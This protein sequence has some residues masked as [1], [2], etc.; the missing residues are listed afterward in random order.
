MP[1]W[2]GGSSGRSLISD[3]LGYFSFQPV[4]NTVAEQ[5]VLPN[6]YGRLYWCSRN[7][8]A[9]EIAAPEKVPPGAAFSSPSPPPLCSATG[10][11]TGLKKKP[12]K[13]TPKKTPS[14]QKTTQK[15]KQ[16]NSGMLYFVC[17]MV[18]VKYPLNIEY[19]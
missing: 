12:T 14:T 9:S 6:I 2:S 1:S 18:Y 13:K 3:P 7:A 8:F 5:G 17:G 10:S 4:L 15:Q 11:T 19:I 16:T